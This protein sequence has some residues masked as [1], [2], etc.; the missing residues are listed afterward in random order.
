MNEVDRLRIERDKMII[1]NYK[2]KRDLEKMKEKIAQLLDRYT[3]GD[4]AD[5]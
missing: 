4:T 1:E 3:E 5:E 2:L